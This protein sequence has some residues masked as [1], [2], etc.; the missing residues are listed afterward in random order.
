MIDEKKIKVGTVALLGRPNAGKSTLLNAFLKQKVSITSPKPQ[1][2][3]FSIEAIYEDARGQIL[4][5]D[6]PGI[7]AKANNAKASDINFTA[8]QSLKDGVDVVVYVVDRTRERGSEE[9]RVLGIIR[10]A[11]IPKILV[12]NKIDKREPNYIEQYM[13][14]EDEFDVIVHVSARTGENLNKIVDNIFALLPEG[15]KIIETKDLPTP[16]LN[17]DSK[18]YLQELIREKAFLRLREELP[19]VIDIRVDEVIER[20]KKDMTVIKARIIAPERYKKMIIGAGGKKIK[21]IGSMARRELELATN[22]K[23][24][25]ELT[26]EAE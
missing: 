26:V 2:T 1:T 3:Q 25:L 10:K 14:L 20:E 5:V 8:E 9:N 13:F 24:Y 18:L 11:Q 12:I 15:E 19:Y 4:F 17:V 22:R 21:E 16:A 23:I 7:F 6:T